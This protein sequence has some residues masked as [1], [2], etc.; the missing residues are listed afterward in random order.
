MLFSSLS[1]LFPFYFSSLSLFFLFP[2]SSLSLPLFETA[3]T[4]NKDGELSSRFFEDKQRPLHHHAQQKLSVAQQRK[5][6]S[7]AGGA[8]EALDSLRMPRD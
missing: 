6:G 3:F 7:G 5:R 4:S 8:T 2:F 1:L